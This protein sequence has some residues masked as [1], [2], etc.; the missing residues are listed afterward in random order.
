MA[1]MAWSKE[2][3]VSLVRTENL[4]MRRVSDMSAVLIDARF[5]LRDTTETF[6]GVNLNVAAGED[7]TFCFG[8]LRDFLRL[9]TSLR[10]SAGAVVF[11]SD[12]SSV[13][14]ESEVRSVGHLCRKLGVLVVD[15]PT[16]P[17]LAVVAAYADQFSDLVSDDPRMLRF[18]SGKLA[19]H[20]VK[21]ARSIE[22]MTPDGVQRNLG[23]PVRHVPTYLALTEGCNHAPTRSGDSQPT[24]AT[25]EAR[26]LIEL[27]G[28]LP[29]IYRHLSTIKSP[30][31]RKKLAN[32][33]KALD[34]RYRD[35]IGCPFKGHS[36]LQGSLEW[37]LDGKENEALLRERGFHSLIRMIAL[38]N[39][40]VRLLTTN[41]QL[42][43]RPSYQA[44][45]NRVEFNGMLVRVA[46]SEVCAIDTEADDKDPRA[47]TL[48]GIALALARGAT[49]FVPFCERD[50]GNLTQNMVR[51]GLTKLF[52]ERIR[53]VGHNLKY[54]FM[55]LQRH[56]IKPP[57]VCF[58]TLLAAHD[59]Y[60]DLDFFSLPFLAQ[61]LLG[62]KI[63]SYM[64][65]VPKGRTFLELPFEEMMEH[66]CVDAEIALHLHRLL[67]RELNSR[68]IDRQFEERTMPLALALLDLE[69]DGIP[70]DGK[71]LEYLRGELVNSMVELKRRI[72]VSLGQYHGRFPRGGSRWLGQGEAWSSRRLGKKGHSL[73]PY[74]S[75]LRVGG[76]CPALSFLSTRSPLT[77]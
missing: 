18:C 73:S 55:L 63:K 17:A 12:A 11:G 29:N 43:P 76:R 14:T 4:L 58:D 36:G 75:S 16:L 35:N 30:I 66:A 44:V 47:A 60:G 64:E 72:S 20:L 37:K 32:N 8:F 13:A 26:R 77:R 71:R 39:A 3:T 23:V 28:S 69:K 70:V 10:I 51:S 33:Q 52:K 15:E 49:F 6:W 53:F 9:R 2:T 41:D 61:R 48:F 42:V 40:P 54:D 65:I 57:M 67:E 24:V 5:L 62:Q 21:G 31:L 46:R 59:C 38:P 45:L 7:N 19:I 68:G 34:D 1:S 27:H 50:M 56:G 25:R 22:R 74:L